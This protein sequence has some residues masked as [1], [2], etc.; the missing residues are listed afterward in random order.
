MMQCGV[1]GQ[2]AINLSLF[3]GF[4]LVVTFKQ[5]VEGGQI[6]WG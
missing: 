5:I 6:R 3:P 2:G 1:E 4:G